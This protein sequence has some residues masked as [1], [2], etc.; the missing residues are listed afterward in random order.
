MAT[1]ELRYGFG[2]NWKD[3]A[4]RSLNEQRIANAVQSMRDLLALDSLKGR[5]L[6]DIGCGSG[7]F[8]LAAGRLGADRVL[9]FD[10]AMSLREQW[11]KAGKGKVLISP[12]S[13]SWLNL[14]R[15]NPLFS[16]VR[17]RLGNQTAD[18]QFTLYLVP[19]EG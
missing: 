13:W 7:L 6:L 17:V 18:F 2:A 1:H 8:S 3:Y 19:Q 16:D 14:S 4:E 12:A 9:S 5:T 15:D 10:G 11:E